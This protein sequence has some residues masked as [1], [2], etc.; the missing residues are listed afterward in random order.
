MGDKEAPERDKDMDWDA[1]DGVVRSIPL[2]ARERAL[3]RALLWNYWADCRNSS[4]RL[5]ASRANLT[6]VANLSILEVAKDNMRGA[7]KLLG[8]L[9]DPI[10]CLGRQMEEA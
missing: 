1:R 7:G 6:D 4:E 9:Q 3:L 5:I 10:D 2:N 8:L